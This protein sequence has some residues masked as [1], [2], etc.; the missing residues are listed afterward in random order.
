VAKLSLALQKIKNLRIQEFKDLR[1]P[2]FLNPS[3]PAS[4]LGGNSSIL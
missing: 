2:Q 3:L 4:L 1:I